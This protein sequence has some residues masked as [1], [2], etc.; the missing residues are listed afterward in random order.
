MVVIHALYM[1]KLGV[2]VM[3]QQLFSLMKCAVYAE[4]VALNVHQAVRTLMMEKQINTVMDVLLTLQTIVIFMILI[5]LFRV[6]CAVFVEVV[7][8]VERS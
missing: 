3:I 6:K 4:V 8:V 7:I 1:S 5:P 2:E